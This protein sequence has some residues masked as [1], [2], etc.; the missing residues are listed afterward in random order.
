MRSLTSVS[1]ADT[2]GPATRVCCA[3]IA[4]ARITC[5]LGLLLHDLDQ[6][7]P[8]ALVDF[9]VNAAGGVEAGNEVALRHGMRPS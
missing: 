3:R 4:R 5:H 6:A 1:M 7:E 8:A 9:Y 2:R